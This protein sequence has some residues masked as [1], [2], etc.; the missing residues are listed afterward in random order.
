M[1][2]FTI[3]LFLYSAVIF[4]N[5]CSDSDQSL[6][7]VEIDG[8]FTRW[9]PVSL[10]FNHQDNRSDEFNDQS[11]KRFLHGIFRNIENEIIVHGYLE[12]INQNADKS[13][14]Q[15]NF[16]PSDYG[17]WS[18]HVIIT[19]ELL[20]T[21]A[22]LEK[23]L[24]HEKAPVCSGSFKI[25]PRNNT[26]FPYDPGFVTY[27]REGFFYR[28]HNETRYIYNGIHVDHRSIVRFNQFVN[29]EMKHALDKTNPIPSLN[30]DSIRV[31]QTD[32]VNIHTIDESITFKPGIN[33]IQVSIPE[34]F[35]DSH[36]MD[37]S[38]SEFDTLNNLQ[39]NIDTLNES[40]LITIL[41][42]FNLQM[43]NQ[44]NLV[45]DQKVRMHLQNMV[46]RFSHNTGLIWKVN[47]TGFLDNSQQE[48]KEITRLIRIL[49]PYNHPIL[50]TCNQDDIAL[51]SFAGYPFIEGVILDHTEE[52]PSEY[53]YEIKKISAQ[54][55]KKW[56]L[57]T[58]T[59][60]I[61]NGEKMMNMIWTGVLAG[62]SGHI[63]STEVDPDLKSLNM[64]FACVNS[65]QDKLSSVTIP[66]STVLTND[67]LHSVNKYGIQSDVELFITYSSGITE[68]KL[69]SLQ[70]GSFSIEWINLDND[71]IYYKTDTVLNGQ[72]NNLTLLSPD[73]DNSIKWLSII[74][75]IN[76]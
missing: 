56:I 29:S 24:N 3:I 27:S 12:N 16:T 64:E 49:D 1:I 61:Y 52:M 41:E 31:V 15:L 46:A 21:K 39:K 44:E 75:A 34:I 26:S 51:E 67:S 53:L 68:Y 38:K 43:Q 30:R 4:L 33:G 6:K 28:G 7:L 17:I 5:A 54:K 72:Y 76:N 42:I 20:T 45:L 74:R 57:F 63:W 70:T 10:T 71:S 62:R 69:D 60:S 9:E 59:K 32:S 55:G 2:R 73:T 40:G 22:E 23:Y 36:E 14:W 35:P 50:I 13:T 18:Y 25:T 48:I 58:Y 11:T 37:Y 19:E 66:Y 47:T 8:T 65:I